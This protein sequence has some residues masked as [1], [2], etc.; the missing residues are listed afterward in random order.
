MRQHWQ[1]YWRPLLAPLRP[2]ARINCGGSTYIDSRGNAWL[3]DTYFSGGGGVDL[4]SVLGSFS[5][6]KTNDQPIYKFER[7][8]DN[9]SFSYTIPIV[10]G[11]YALDLHFCENFYASAGQRIGTVALNGAN[12]LGNFDIFAEAG[13]QRV[14]L[15][16][17]FKRQALNTLTLTFTNTLVNGI[18]LFKT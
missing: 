2:I 12:I 16:K 3:A 1:A 5:V 15:I 7:S 8:L 10:S 9:N 11:T 6:I 13:G 14:A 18:E 17:T 4:E